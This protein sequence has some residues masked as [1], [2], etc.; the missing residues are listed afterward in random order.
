MECENIYFNG[1]LFKR[2]PESKRPELRKYFSGKCKLPGDRNYKRRRLHRYKWQILKGEIPAGYEIHHKDE[3][4]L[5]NDIDNL[6]CIT[7]AEHLNKHKLSISES[8]KQKA[9]ENLLKFAIPK[10]KEW[11][12]SE[13]GK[14]WHRK[15]AAKTL[16]VSIKKNCRNCGNEFL[17]IRVRQVHCSYSCKVKYNNSKKSNG[18]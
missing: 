12:K 7:K 5:N 13:A 11:H 9:T 4:P 15:H 17:A 18:K 16:S 10:S 1:F 14:E 6:E 3:N 8:Q 2:Y